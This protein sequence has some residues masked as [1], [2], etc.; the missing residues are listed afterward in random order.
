[1]VLFITTKVIIQRP[2]R[3]FNRKTQILHGA[4][5]VMKSTLQFRHDYLQ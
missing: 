5:E 1:M 3:F 4:D 2:S